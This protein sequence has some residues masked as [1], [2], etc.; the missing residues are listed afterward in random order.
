MPKPIT[1]TRELIKAVSTVAVRLIDDLKDGKISITEGIGYLSDFTVIR[2]G[3]QGITEIPGELADL[4]DAEREMLL[5]DISAAL[6]AAGLSHRIADAAEKIL[7]WAY[8]TVRT[9][10]DIRSAPPVALPA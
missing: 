7:R 1:E 4:T 6:T 10:V 9:F 5:E 8:G 3:L 2:T